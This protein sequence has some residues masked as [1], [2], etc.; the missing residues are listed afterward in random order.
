M[1]CNSEHRGWSCTRVA[2]HDGEHLATNEIED[3]YPAIKGSLYAK[4]GDA[5]ANDPTPGSIESR[6]RILEAAVRD[7]QGGGR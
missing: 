4:W 1:G 5:D 7:L 2:E 3:E 6:L